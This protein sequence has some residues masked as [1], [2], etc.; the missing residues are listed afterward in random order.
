[1]L[2]NSLTY[3]DFHQITID[4]V[5]D[6]VE[7]LLKRKCVPTSDEVGAVAFDLGCILEIMNPCFD[8]EM[9][10]LNDLRD[11]V[12]SWANELEEMEKIL[13]INR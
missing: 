5:Q 9:Y 12:R 11:A 1:M 3:H 13:N 7:D 4:V 8:T 6:H 10:F 2:C